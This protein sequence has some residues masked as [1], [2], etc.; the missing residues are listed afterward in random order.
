MTSRFARERPFAAV[1]MRTL[2]AFIVLL[3]IQ[4]ACDGLARSRPAADE[5]LPSPPDLKLLRMAAFG[6]PAALARLLTLRIQSADY[7]AG[8]ESPDQTMD[9]GV[10][11]S[12]LSRVLALDPI[13]QYPLLLASRVYADVPNHSKQRE[14]LDF[15]AS[16][17]LK[18]P[19][20]RWPWLAQATIVAKHQ[21]KD[22]A[23]A[24]QYAHTLQAAVR[25]ERV[26]LWARQMEVF[27]LEDMNE[28][29]AARIMLGGMLKEGGILDADEAR[30]LQRKLDALSAKAEESRQ[31]N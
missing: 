26:P 22:L 4:L 23:L 16:E 25:P 8:S 31:K 5:I 7:R 14:M 29:E 13:A 11:T 2:A 20:R 12:W 17:F 3:A 6:E 27:I 24:R 18:D 19:D 15:V 9:Y 10:L 1:P 30:F 28:F 21:L